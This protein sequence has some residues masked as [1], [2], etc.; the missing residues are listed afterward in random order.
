MIVYK[1]DCAQEGLLRTQGKRFSPATPGGIR[2]FK[3]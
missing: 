1:E 3:S 2:A